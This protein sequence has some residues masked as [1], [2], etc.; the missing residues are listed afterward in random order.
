MAVDPFQ[1][2]FGLAELTQTW[3]T[4][5]GSGA[6]RYFRHCEER[7]IEPKIGTA[8]NGML[9]EQQSISVIEVFPGNVA[10]C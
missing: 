5:R 6:G 10:F 8:F 2:L 7:Q 1:T 3:R 9:Y 4:S